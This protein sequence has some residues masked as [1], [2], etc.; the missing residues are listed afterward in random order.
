MDITLS[1]TK[2]VVMNEVAKQTSYIG[3]KITFQDGSNA[4]DQVFTTEDDFAMLEKYWR[5]ASNATATNLRRFVKS[6]EEDRGHRYRFKASTPGFRSEQA[7]SSHYYT[8]VCPND[9]MIAKLAQS[10]LR[11]LIIS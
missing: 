6:I 10:N 8:E 7:R 3:G 9:T 1:I 4:Y 5:E 2:S 11:Y